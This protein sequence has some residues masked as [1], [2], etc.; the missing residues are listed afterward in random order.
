VV[1]LIRRIKPQTRFKRVEGVLYSRNF[2]V[3]P[4]P[5]FRWYEPFVLF[6]K[7][8]FAQFRI[9]LRGGA[10]VAFAHAEGKPYLLVASIKSE[11]DSELLPPRAQL[12]ARKAYVKDHRLGCLV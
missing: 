1:P 6:L 3:C 10:E 5:A 4:S 11:T 7:G 9:M 8:Q 12:T 2:T